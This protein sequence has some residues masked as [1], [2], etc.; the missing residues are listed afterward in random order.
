MTPHDLD[1]IRS[2]LEVYER[3]MSRGI[4]RHAG[5]V[6]GDFIIHAPADLKALL[7]E[8]AALREREVRAEGTEA[9]P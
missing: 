8:V 2:R 7:D 9:A 4:S 1:A 6:D 3:L 5:E